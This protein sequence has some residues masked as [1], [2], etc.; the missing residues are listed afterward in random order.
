MKGLKVMAIMLCFLF[1][2]AISALADVGVSGTVTKEKTV[3]VEEIIN[4]KKNVSVDV[5]LDVEGEKAAEAHAVLNQSQRGNFACE[6][7]AEKTSGVFGS[8]LNNMGIVNLNQATGNMANQSNM[9]SAAVDNGN[10]EP[11]AE[12]YGFAHAQTSVG[13]VMK[14]NTIDSI[15]ILYRDAVI[16]GS[17]NTNTGVVM[18]NQSVGNIS[19]QGNVLTLGVSLS[20]LVALAEADLGQAIAGNSFREFDTTKTATI[21]GS[22]NENM[23]VV[24]VNQSAGV[25]GNQLNAVN[26]S[27]SVYGM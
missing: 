14:G 1:V 20:G 4:I 8:I 13:Q 3:D 17:I 15:Q 12:G 7:C 22:I 23:G 25:L 19:N 10:G 9:L 18:V 21:S 2:G 27:A 24:E 5:T 11:P 16:T 26:I 6:N